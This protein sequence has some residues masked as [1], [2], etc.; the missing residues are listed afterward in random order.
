MSDRVFPWRVRADQ[1]RVAS[2][3]IKRIARAANISAQASALY[4]ATTFHNRR[5]PFSR[6]STYLEK[7]QSDRAGSGRGEG[8]KFVT[9][10]AVEKWSKVRPGISPPPPPRSLSFCTFQSPRYSRKTSVQQG[11]SECKWNRTGFDA[12]RDVGVSRK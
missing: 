2:C 4:Q 9:L 12:I 7:I 6:G 5:P 11:E 8:S 1:Y 10:C 3:N